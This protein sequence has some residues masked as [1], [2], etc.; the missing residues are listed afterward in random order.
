M[1]EGHER[2]VVSWVGR[3][4]GDIFTDLDGSVWQVQADYNNKKVILVKVQESQNPIKLHT[5]CCKLT[6]RHKF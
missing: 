6:I 2:P 5:R 1:T 3:R 4:I